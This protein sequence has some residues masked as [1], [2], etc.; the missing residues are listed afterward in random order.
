MGKRRCKDCY[1]PRRRARYVSHSFQPR[2]AAANAE[3]RGVA[4]IGLGPASCMIRGPAGTTGYLPLVFGRVVGGRLLDPSPTL[5]LACSESL[6]GSSR[7]S[8]RIGDPGTT[9]SLAKARLRYRF[10][11]KSLKT[12]SPWRS[13]HD[14]ELRYSLVRQFP[15]ATRNSNAR[16]SSFV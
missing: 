8:V 2:S 10:D 14:P 7:G 5:F 1:T 16:N 15:H 9:F 11:S 6:A 12:P 3:D 13:G 4:V